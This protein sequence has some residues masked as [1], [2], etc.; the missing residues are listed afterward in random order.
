MK[1]DHIL[2][3]A[4]SHTD[5]TY[6]EGAATAPSEPAARIAWIVV[7]IAVPLVGIL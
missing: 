4:Y 7:I 2:G 6:S 3:P 1:S 5:R